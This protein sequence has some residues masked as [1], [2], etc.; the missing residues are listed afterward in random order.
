MDFVRTTSVIMLV[1][2]LFFLVQK[3]EKNFLRRMNMMNF[4]K[5]MV[6]FISIVV[7]ISFSTMIVMGHFNQAFAGVCDASKF[8]DASDQK[9]CCE[10]VADAI[11]TACETFA[12]SVGVAASA[13]TSVV[14]AVVAGG[15][16]AVGAT[17]VKRH[18][19]ITRKRQ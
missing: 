13:A 10:N 1:I 5:K 17:V 19:K 16:A 12:A 7:L 11:E 14:A 2:L 6:S 4:N 3:E 8:E 15:A 18:E 9:E